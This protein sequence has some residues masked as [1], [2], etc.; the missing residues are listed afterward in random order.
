M[1][2]SSICLSFLLSSLMLNWYKVV[3]PRGASRRKGKKEEE[4]EKNPDKT[5]RSKERKRTRREDKKEGKN[6][7]FWWRLQRPLLA[8]LKSYQRVEVVGSWVEGLRRGEAGNRFLST[9]LFVT[10]FL[11]PSLSTRSTYSSSSHSFSSCSTSSSC[12]SPFSSSSSFPTSLTSSPSSS[13]GILSKQDQ[14]WDAEETLKP[15]LPSG[16]NA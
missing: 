10:S 9:L 5:M 13:D 8:P 1:C 7:Y 12:F 15:W 11:I 2:P 14:G 4:E 3:Q 6:T 16:R